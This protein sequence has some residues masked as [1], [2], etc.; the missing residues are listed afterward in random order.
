MG[1]K[2]DNHD[3]RQKL[4]LRRYFLHKYHRDGANVFDCC[5]GSGLLWR[6]LRAEFPVN[7]YWGV[8]LK[9]KKGR[10]KIDS[11]RILQQ[12]GWNQDV[13]DVDTYGSPWKHWMAMMPNVKQPTTVFLTIGQAMGKM[14]TMP[15][16]LELEAVGMHC[17]P[18]LSRNHK[19]AC[20]TIGGKD[21]PRKLLAMSVQ[22]AAS[23]LLTRAC[24]YGLIVVEAVEVA[25]S[26]SNQSARYLGV[27]LAP[28]D[29]GPEVVTPARK[30]KRRKSDKETRNV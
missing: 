22:T 5:Q 20:P 19:R 8:D 21:I 30:S 25:E 23:A 3:P 27:R 15:S 29:S 6:T 14:M 4:Q 16:R 2:T 1:K 9:Q 24:E 17:F 18:S 11:V 10:L 13:I 28:N 7:G 12:E 26:A